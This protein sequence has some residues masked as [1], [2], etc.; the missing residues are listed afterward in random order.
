M[1]GGKI[2]SAFTS[3]FQQGVGGSALAAEEAPGV[4]G[5]V[6]TVLADGVG[7]GLW[8]AGCE[9]CS[10]LVGGDGQGA[11]G[12]ISAVLQQQEALMASQQQMVRASS[13]SHKLAQQLSTPLKTVD[14]E[15]T[16]TA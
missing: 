2:F 5:K 3:G 4:V 12:D 8:N 6:G 7:E 1:D 16:A 14:E 15:D 10:E 13:S 9:A 11:G